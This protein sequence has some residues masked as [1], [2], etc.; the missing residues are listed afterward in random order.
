MM[1]QRKIGQNKSEIGYAQLS[2]DSTGKKGYLRTVQG[3]KRWW[4]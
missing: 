2:G 3:E 1:N 4:W